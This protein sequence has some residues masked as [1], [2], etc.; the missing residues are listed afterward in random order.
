MAAMKIQKMWRGF[1][2]R[3]QTRRKKMEEMV[4]IGML[5]APSLHANALE[6]VENI[7]QQRYKVQVEYQQLYEDSL[8]KFEDEINKKQGAAMTEDMA[9]EIRNWFRDFYG[10]TGKFPDFP[11]EEAGG[12]RHLLSRQGT[13]SELSRSSALSSR[14]SKKAGKDKAVKGGKGDEVVVDEPF[15][16]GF[17]PE[18]SS[19]LPELKLGIDEYV[20]Y[21]NFIILSA[22]PL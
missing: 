16:K 11:S 21:L 18:Q 6:D 12:S 22:H 13:E 5:P 7:R 2:S 3:T 8:K 4:L 10:R 1:S 17:K 9:D 14:E 15:K 19:F 20:I